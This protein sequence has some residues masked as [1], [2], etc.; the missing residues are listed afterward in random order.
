MAERYLVV[1]GIY[2]HFKGGEYL[3]E[4]VATHTETDEQLVVYVNIHHAE[5]V[6]ARPYKDFMSEVDRKKYPEA[7]QK[8][9]FEL[10][11]D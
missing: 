2:K 3:V 11:G 10:K 4:C 7:S 9:R 8:F 5:K 6:F 1:G